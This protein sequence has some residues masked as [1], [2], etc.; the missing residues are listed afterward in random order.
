MALLYYVLW[1]SLREVFTTPTSWQL[2][3]LPPPES[4]LKEGQD[5]ARDVAP[6]AYLG[7]GSC[8]LTTQNFPVGARS[9]TS[10]GTFRGPS[11]F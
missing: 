6:Q 1:M 10:L 2:E 7:K 8:A 3:A 11:Y 5:V 4:G 9:A